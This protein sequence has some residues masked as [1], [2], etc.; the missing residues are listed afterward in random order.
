MEKEFKVGDL[1]KCTDSRQSSMLSNVVVYKV[2]TIIINSGGTFIEPE[3]GQVRKGANWSADGFKRINKYRKNDIVLTLESTTGYTKCRIVELLH[4]QS[5]RVRVQ[6]RISGINENWSRVVN[7]EY[8]KPV[9][10]PARTLTK[11]NIRGLMKE[12]WKTGF[13][14]QTEGRA[15][16]PGDDVDEIL[17]KFLKNKSE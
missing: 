9:T 2:D 10:K 13:N 4:F 16:T 7:E 5:E 8:L 14:L 11:R 12:A 3:G 17:E 6:Y 1:V 15:I